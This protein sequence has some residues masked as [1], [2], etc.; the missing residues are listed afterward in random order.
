[1]S[2]ILAGL[3]IETLA[4]SRTSVYVGSSTNDHAALTNEDLDFTIKNKATG[5]LPSLLANRVS[6]FYDLKGAS[7]VI[8]TA[9]SSSLVALHM[10]CLDIRAGGSE[11]VGI[12]VC[13]HLF[14][15]T[16]H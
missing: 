9:C 13:M 7:I 3:P 15:K 14:D 2:G 1:M 10:A 11:M 4:G 5:T 12:H 8:D 6:W 16:L